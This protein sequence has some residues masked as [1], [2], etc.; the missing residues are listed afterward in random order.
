MLARRS[1]EWK[2]IKEY[3]IFSQKVNL[4]SGTIIKVKEV[5]TRTPRR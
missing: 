1:S 2:E 4:C 5:T 3:T